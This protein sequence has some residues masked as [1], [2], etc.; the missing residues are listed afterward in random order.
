MSTWDNHSDDIPSYSC[1]M[2]RSAAAGREATLW[3]HQSEKCSKIQTRRSKP[4]TGWTEMLQNWRSF[5]SAQKTGRVAALHIND[6]TMVCRHGILALNV[7]LENTF[8]PSCTHSHMRELLFPVNTSLP[9]LFSLRVPNRMRKKPVKLGVWDTGT[10]L[11]KGLPVFPLPR[12]DFSHMGEKVPLK[13]IFSPRISSEDA[14]AADIGAAR[15]R[16]WGGGH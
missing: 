16:C 14:G 9:L 2:G 7:P 5:L 3:P 8:A 15:T 11:N 6:L 13:S 1:P 12:T 4:R 10:S